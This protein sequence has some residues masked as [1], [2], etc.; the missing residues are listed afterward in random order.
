MNRK[1]LRIYP[2]LAI[3]LVQAALFGQMAGNPS[4][5]QGWKELTIG[6]NGTYFHQ[7]LAGQMAFSRRIL[8]KVEWG[9]AKGVDV[10]LNAGQTQ[11]KLRTHKVIDYR[12]KYRFAY[13]G[14]FNALL[15]QAAFRQGKIGYWIGAKGL[16]YPSEGSYYLT[17]EIGENSLTR[18]FDM[19]YN[20]RE[21]S[22]HAG[23]LAP[24]RALRFY[25]ALVA[26][27]IQRKEE[28]Q[29]YLLGLDE[30]PIYIGKETATYQS[31][32][33]TGGLL[34][35]DVVLPQRYVIS[36]EAALF[37]EENYQVMVGVSQTG[38][39]QW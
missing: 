8:G 24:F 39:Q 38:F 36:V 17:H 1:Q 30:D 23:I 33:W 12:D 31:E 35:L 2:V 5:S 32:L 27:G 11:L 9:L 15:N 21:Y 10:Y 13:G 16:V 22:F 6:V 20:S 4:T 3:I 37:N 14:G 29:E 34:G 25:A 26:W 7:Q 28:K 19:K 18:Q